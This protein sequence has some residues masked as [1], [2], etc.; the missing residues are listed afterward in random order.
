MYDLPRF[1]LSD[2]SQCSRALR[3]LSA[4]ADSM[5]SVADRI[6][7]HLYTHLIDLETKSRACALVRFYKTHPY[8]SLGPALQAFAQRSAGSAPLTEAVACLTLLATAGDL[9][10]WNV[11]QQ[12]TGH[13]AIP[14]IS[15]EMVLQLPMVAQLTHQF[16]LP[17]SSIL[18]PDRTLLPDLDQQTYNVFYVPEAAGSPYV[19][20][21][22]EFVAPHRIKSVLGFGGMLPT[23]EL[24][25]IILFTKVALPRHVADLFKS[26][27]LSAKLAV[28]P[29]SAGPIFTKTHP[30]GVGR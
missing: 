15:A 28:L 1:T 10:E 24:M 30:D 23:G 5:E 18:E 2:M 8:G 19:P 20:A 14:L 26:L 17:V 12:S 11:R 4:E 7:K 22:D 25:A 21:Q 13:Q 3:E 16:G 27:A 29:F 9:A 6:V